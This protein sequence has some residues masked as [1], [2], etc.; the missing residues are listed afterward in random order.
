[1]ELL[2]AA[3]RFVGVCDVVA[4]QTVSKLMTSPL[5][6]I[7]LLPQSRVIVTG[8]TALTIVTEPAE[9]LPRSVVPEPSI[10]N[11][12]PGKSCNRPTLAKLIVA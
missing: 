9:R 11:V 12:E 8:L 1:M 6:A 5:F 3:G 10:V 7:T 2:L 4:P